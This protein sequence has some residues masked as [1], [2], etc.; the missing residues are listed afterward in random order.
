LESAA[1]ADSL[2]DPM[3][4]LYGSDGAELA[5]DDDG[6]EG[7]NS[8][9]E[10]Q[11]PTAGVYF[12]EAR[13]FVEEAEGR[14]IISVTPGEIG[15][16]PDTAEMLQATGDPRQSFIGTAGDVDW[17]V[18]ELVMRKSRRPFRSFPARLKAAAK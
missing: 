2:G 6:G 15:A 3:L 11:A 4:V 10:F 18:I 7:L 5:R 12:V 16:S 8:W 17:F 9:L 1:V 13:G 14:Y